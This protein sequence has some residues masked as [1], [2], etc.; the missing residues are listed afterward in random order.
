[1][2]TE[3]SYYVPEQSR[4][5]IFATI[6]LFLIAF[7][8]ANWINGGSAYIF[9]AGSLAMAAVL[10]FWFSTVIQENMAGLN[11]DQLKRSYVWGMGWFIFSEVM[12]FAA[13]FGALYYIRT[14]A[15]PWLGG[16]GDKGSSNMLW[17]GFE[18]TWPLM[19]TPD[20]AVHGD[21]AKIV[22]PK[23][24]IDP[25]HLPLINTLIL[26]ASSF[27]VHVAHVYLKKNKRNAFNLW[28]TITVALGF[29]FLYFQAVEYYEAYK[30]LGLTLES[31]IYGTTF[32][33]LTGFHGAHVT[34]GT[35]MLLIM[36]LRS[37]IAQHFRP[38]DHFGFEAASWYW[39]FVDVVW[40]ALFIF[41][42]VLGG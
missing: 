15:L 20:A 5:P 12:F 26:L 6:G 38:D 17:Q 27:T 33:M 36:L 19:V 11:S 41:V 31:G 10:W 29:A 8:A 35:I 21:A 4:L 34:L 7:G 28:L 40:V 24:I 14:F 37:V 39:H 2:A 32:F 9:F 23:A 25:W 3:S 22:G 16:E 30:H 42:Y 18:N 13:F 1:M